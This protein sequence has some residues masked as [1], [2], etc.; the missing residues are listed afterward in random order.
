MLVDCGQ[1]DL[2]APV[3]SYWHE[4]AQAGKSKMPVR[5]LLTHQAGLL[6]LEEVISQAQL[7]NWNYVVDRLAA[8]RP[9]W[10]PGS[11]HGYH[12]LTYGFLVGEV[13]RRVAGC[14]AGQYVQREIAGPLG[15][16]LFIGLPADQESRVAP[17]L[18]P[19][20]SAE[21]PKL[22]D[23]GPYALRALNWISPPLIPSDIN[24][25]DV[26]VAEL[27]AANGI[28]NARALARIFASMIG[29]VDGVR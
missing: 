2:N 7:L 3:A 11:Q 1:L 9:D 16:D 18:L 12:S 22:P 17:A 6:G 23:T 13:I 25:H 21:T 10:S 14:S 5:W 28:G 24:R 20:L 19:D 26:R 4:F 27:P 15:A 8:Q 29:P